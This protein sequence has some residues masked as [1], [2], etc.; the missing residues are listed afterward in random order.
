[1]TFDRLLALYSKFEVLCGA[2]GGDT[3]AHED[4]EERTDY[5]TLLLYCMR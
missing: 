2:A 3:S 1:M 4:Y 5:G